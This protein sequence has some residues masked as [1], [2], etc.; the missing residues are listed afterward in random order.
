MAIDLFVQ[1]SALIL[2]ALAVAFVMRLLKQPLIIG[3]IITGIFVGPFFLN[4][5]GDVETFTTFSEIG[6]AFLL[7]I[8]GLHLSPKVIKEVGKVSLITGLGQIV[9]TSLIGFLIC[10]ALGF[11]WIISIYLAIA[12]TFS[13][14]IIIMK[15]LSDKDALEKL[16]GKI[17]IGFL[18]VQDFVAIIILIVVSSFSSGLSVG[19]L[20]SS[21]LIRGIFLVAFLAMVGYYVLPRLSNFFAKSQEFLFLF[22]V[23][24][25][26]GLASLFFYAGFS[27]E[28][29]ALIAGVILSISP[30]SYEISS[31]LRPLRDFFIISFFILL[32]AQMVFTDIYNLIIPA[33]LLS[34]FILIGNPLVVIMLMGSLGYSKRTG[35]MAGLTV[36]QISEFSLIL[37]ALA[38]KVGHISNEILSFITLIGLITIAGSTYMIMYSEKIYPYISRYLSLFEKKELKDKEF[39]E[40]EFDYVLLGYNRIGFSILKSFSKL[41]GDYVAVDYNPATISKLCKNKINCI[42]GDVGDIEFLH[43]I[44]IEKAKLI[45]STVPEIEANLLLLNKIKQKNKDAVVIVTG[46]QISEAFKLYDA[47]A[48]YVILPHFL[49]GDYISTLIENLKADKIKYKKEKARQIASLKERLKEGH[50]HPRVERD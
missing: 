5:L 46:R 48:D 37:V 36:A 34:I 14:T 26:M 20:I 3:Y 47:G 30:Y 41:K 38:V 35:F 31:K 28:V 45:V 44:R 22:A 15:L 17:S 33:I 50:R 16:Y 40:K 8:V 42:Y 11:N 29:G 39:V 1:I 7:F 12:L 27:I 43:E 2:T 10:I 19:S 6:I 21:T 24:W 25:G 13:S 49:G 9:F 32:G 4:I 18:L 23:A